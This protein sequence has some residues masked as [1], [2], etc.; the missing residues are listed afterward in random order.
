MGRDE[1]LGA[2]FGRPYPVDD[3]HDGLV[4]DPA[5][6]VR[7][8]SRQQGHLGRGP[9]CGRP[10]GCHVRRCDRDRRRD[11]RRHRRERGRRYLGCRVPAAY[12]GLERLRDRHRRDLSAARSRRR[13]PHLQRGVHR[14]LDEFWAGDDPNS[15]ATWVFGRFEL[16]T[17]HGLCA[18]GRWRRRCPCP[19]RRD[20]GRQGMPSP[21]R[22]V[23]G[24]VHLGVPR[25][26]HAGRRA[27]WSA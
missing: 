1:G 23:P 6:R 14:A 24:G 15:P 12:R 8:R 2:W 16:P 13:R 10:V 17:L 9:A 20:A 22:H 26:H 25:T 11:V 19:H 7:P 4:G 3:D 18:S 21:C 5:G 27:H